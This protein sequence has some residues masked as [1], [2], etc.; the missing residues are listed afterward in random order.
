MFCDNCWNEEEGT[1]ITCVPR[2]DAELAHISR[3]A[4][5][6]KAR[7][8]AYAK[9]SV[10][11]EDLKS[12]VVSCRECNAPVGRGKFCPECGTPVSLTKACTSCSAEIPA[13]AKFCPEC[14]AKP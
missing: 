10:S 5:F 12:K 11:N 13:G 3:E 4:K 9:A 14:G 2:L 6:Q 1:C 8:V 7:E